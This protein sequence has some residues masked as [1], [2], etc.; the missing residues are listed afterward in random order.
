MKLGRWEVYITSRNL[1]VPERCTLYYTL[2]FL[3][4][5]NYPSQSHALFMHLFQKCS[6]VE[7]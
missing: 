3:F 4:H 2:P 5:F 1:L 7:M 6:M